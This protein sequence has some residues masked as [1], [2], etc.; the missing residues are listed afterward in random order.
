MTLSY[1]EQRKLAAIDRSL[2]HDPTLRALA[3]LFAQSIPSSA[4]RVP[5]A[6]RG[7]QPSHPVADL[8]Q[9]AH[10]YT[11]LLVLTGVAMAAGAVCAL[12]AAPLNL[13]AVAMA[14]ILLGACAGVSFVA[15]W[16]RREIRS[17]Q[18]RSA[19]AQQWRDITRPSVA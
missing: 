10:R 6:L 16:V 5:R 3:S 7:H 17:G 8:S 2:S 19:S 1:S 4:G 15:L 18:Q 14:G 9:P 11:A 13:M 12:V